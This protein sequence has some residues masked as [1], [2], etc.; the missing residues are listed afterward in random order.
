MDRKKRLLIISVSALVLETVSI[1][2]WASAFQIWEQDGASVA[3]FHAGYAAEANDA[4]IAFYNPAGMVRIKNQQ[5]IFGADSVL[6]DIKYTGTVAVNT[7][8]NT[9]PQPVTAQGGVF[10]AVPFLQYVA[11]ISDHVGFG[12]S[13]VVPFGAQI[14]YGRNTLLRYASTY[15]SIKVIDMSPTLA[16]RVLEK[17]SIGLGPDLQKMSV[18]FNQTAGLG[19]ASFDT[20]STNRADDTAW[21]Y[22]LGGLYEFTEDTRVG[23]SYHS[24]V[25]HHLS[26]RSSFSGALAN[27]INDNAPLISR[28]TA[29]ITLP[30]YTA[31]SLF[32]RCHSP[33]SVM[34]SVI[35]TQWT[36]VRNL[37][38]KNLA[39]IDTGNPSTSLEVTV[40]Q[41][42]RNTWNFSIGANYFTTETITLKGGLG[43][44]ETPV[45]KEYRNVQLPDNNHYII[46]LGGHY[47]AT[48]AIGVDVGWNHVFIHKA[49]VSPPTQ[50]TGDQQVTTKGSVIGGADVYAAQIT[51][52]IF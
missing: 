23:L 51:W 7:L 6:T 40:P 34:A 14:N 42:F 4:S 31:L 24:Q 21:G 15:S 44:D 5:I 32:H 10:T 33:F 39:G 17:A 12:F 1:K 43:Y 9:N 29:N 36:T 19:D 8:T 50:I 26:R 25:V 30:P 27:T 35:Y 38:M 45:Q 41:N 2:A 13:V 18:E 28:A 48:K 22:H 47:Q 20:D 37:V 46:A 52:D 11:P 49:H 3:N 16:L